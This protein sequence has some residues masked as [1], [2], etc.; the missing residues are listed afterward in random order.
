VGDFEH[1]DDLFRIVNSVDNSIVAHSV[2]IAARQFAAQRFDI[3]ATWF[4]FSR[5]KQ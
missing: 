5:S 1:K 2:A 4:F 3:S